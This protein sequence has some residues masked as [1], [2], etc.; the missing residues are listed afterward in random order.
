MMFDDYNERV[1]AGVL[2]K[3]IGVYP[4]RSLL[5]TNCGDFDTVGDM[6]ISSW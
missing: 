2:G 3:T 5:S 1:Y 6:E 4:G